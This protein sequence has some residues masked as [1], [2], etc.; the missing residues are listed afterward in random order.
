MLLYKFIIFLEGYMLRFLLLDNFRIFSGKKEIKV[1]HL[2]KAKEILKYLIIN[3]EK[4]VPINEL[5]ELFW[6]DVFFESDDI[7]SLKINLNTS[8]YVIRKT[9]NLSPK[10]LYIDFDSCIFDP[11]SIYVDVEDFVLNYSLSQESN[12]NDEKIKYLLYAEKLYKTDFLCENMYDSWVD[13]KREYFKNVYINIINEIADFY[14]GNEQLNTALSYIEKGFQIDR[15]RDDLWIKQ[16]AIYIRKENYLKAQKI[17]NDY[18]DMF[19]DDNIDILKNFNLVSLKNKQKVFDSYK[20]NSLSVKDFNKVVE[21]E[22]HKRYKDF[23]VCEL[24][25]KDKTKATYFLDKLVKYIR[26]EDLICLDEDKIMIMF[27]EIKDIENGKKIIERKLKEILKNNVEIL[28][29]I[30]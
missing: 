15:D 4:K 26:Q 3:R 24:L 13:I 18:K 12:S 6:K 11:K 2:K 10:Y 28:N 21:V 7:A 17:Y 30:K 27:R 1:F 25:V 23:F 19:K 14:M 16:I 8:L 9:L 20:N 5:F 29:N 22:N